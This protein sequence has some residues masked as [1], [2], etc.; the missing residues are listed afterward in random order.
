[1]SERIDLGAVSAYAIAVENGFVGTEADWLASLKGVKG[2]SGTD[3]TNGKSAY[4]LAVDNG[5][6]GT[7]EQWIA[8]LKG[9]KG[10]KGEDG[11]SYDDTEVKSEISEL[12]SA[13]GKSYHYED[14]TDVKTN[15]LQTSDLTAWGG[16]WDSVAN[17]VIIM[18]STESQKNIGANTP[19]IGLSD[20]YEISATFES[21]DFT[22]TFQ[23]V[24]MLYDANNNRQFITLFSKYNVNVGDIVEAS[25]TV[26]VPN[27]V[28]YHNATSVK[29]LLNCSY[30]NGQTGGT[31]EL[32][33]ITLYK[34][35]PLDDL[36]IYADNFPEMIQKIYEA[37]PKTTQQ[38]QFI[39]G[40]DGENYLLKVNAS[41]N[42]VNIPTVPNKAIF[43]GNS[44]L[45]G[46]GNYGMCA[47][48]SQ[49]D[50]Y[51]YVTSAI[52]EKNSN[53]T[54]TKIAPNKWEQA[55]TLNSV[56][57]WL[58]DNDSY[59]TSDV[60]LIILQIGDNVNTN[61]KREI[62]NA[63]F[64]DTVHTLLTKCPNAR[65]I[66]VGF[67]FN[68]TS[69]S[70]AVMSAVNHYGLEY[71]DI[72]TLHTKAN[73]AVSGQT[74]VDGNGNTQVVPDAWITHPGNDGML[75]IANKIIET[76]NL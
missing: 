56:S 3:G 32:S 47:T 64:D 13:K 36:D 30:S 25:A 15:E 34:K 58:A 8:S 76:L 46:M 41:G 55:E 27:M 9:A 67:W 48:D 61:A 52:L 10:D 14:I 21:I 42:L 7:E 53:A 43:V 60:D 75:A 19:F 33:N 71:V 31:Y 49:H 44:L 2:D 16:Q 12:Q 72:T 51:H 70:P 38:A 40:G 54:F 45:F 37:I 20:I 6:V 63:T 1:M 17:D 66:C 28:V 57:E 4:Q 65:I 74:Y 22:G 29:L 11:E 50:Y 23:I 5:F 69:A 26:D 68:A 59:F 24:A 73:E 18:T 62:W 35:R 39:R